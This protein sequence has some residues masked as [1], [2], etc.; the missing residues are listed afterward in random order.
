VE[1]VAV[2]VCTYKRN[3]QLGRLLDSLLHLTRPATTMFVIVDND[4]RDPETGA[5]VAKFQE[6]CGNR[7]DYV[8]EP[9]VGISAARNAAFTTA[10]KAGATALAMLDDDEW[11]SPGWLM[12]FLEA[13]DATGARVIGGPVR[14]IFG[15]KRRP[16]ERY[17]RLWTVQRGALNGQLHVYCTCNCLVQVSAMELLGDQPFPDEFGLTGGE[18]VVFFRRLHFAG[19]TMAWCD[20]AVVFEEIP[21]NHA[22]FAWMRRRWY[23]HGNA[24]VRCERAAPN[25]NGIPPLA[26]TALLCGRLFAYPLF[27]HATLRMP[28]LWMLE[29]EKVRGRI[30]AHLGMVLFDYGRARSPAEANSNAGSKHG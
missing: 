15:G 21:E 25:P 3:R 1:R 24:G 4:G 23:R 9:K 11:P 29:A 13:R 28:M 2:C 5:L 20:E 10:R 30:A 18:D 19:V 14:P 26:K 22:T 8:T 27:N 7:V 12:R 16:P 17:E 6:T